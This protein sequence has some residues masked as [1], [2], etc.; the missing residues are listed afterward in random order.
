MPIVARVCFDESVFL[1]TRQN[2]Y[3]SIVYVPTP[4][5]LF[6][7]RKWLNR[8]FE[9]FCTFLLPRIGMI[10]SLGQFKDDA[11]T[12]NWMLTTWDMS[13]LRKSVETNLF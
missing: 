12:V 1:M 13:A 8:Y 9:E 6:Y 2:F 7:E 5:P 4:P 11:G 3:T 10:D